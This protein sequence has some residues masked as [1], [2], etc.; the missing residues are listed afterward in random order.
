MQK[1][2]PVDSDGAIP[3]AK[4]RNVVPPREQLSYF[5][6]RVVL[7]VLIL[8]VA[9]L[10]WSGIHVLL[11]AFAG[12]AFAVFL[13][14]LSDWLCARTGWPY[15]RALSVLVILL[16]L[17]GCGFT[18]LLAHH[19]MVQVVGLSQKL[20]ESLETARKYLEE[21]P[22]G[23]DLLEQAPTAAGS[24]AQAGALTRLTGLASGAV[25]VALAAVVILFVGV[26]GA[27]EP[28]VYKHGLLHLVPL[29]ERDRVDQA[30]DAVIFNLRW[31]LVGQACLMAMLGMTTAVGL[32]LVGIPFA[33]TLGLITGIMAMIPYLGAWLSAVPAA[34]IALQMGPRYF[35][36][37]VALFFGLHLLEGYLLAPLVQRRTV[38]MPP[39][40]TLIV[41]ILLG[42]LV[43]VVGLLI[44]APLTVAVVVFLKLLYIEDALGDETIEQPE[45]PKEVAQSHRIKGS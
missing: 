5:A 16:V 14:T 20:P 10:V 31:W 24:L 11:L 18:W 17:L 33:V 25:D 7:T 38:H 41:Q 32:W 9:Y 23:S 22:W 6:W 28:D 35:G 19:V 3:A 43:G 15:R 27:A 36:M 37:T 39:A 8:A 45:E 26:F 21:Y 42:E 13:A 1:N 4:R 40:L 29:G 44:A 30:L 12:M 2:G 34:L